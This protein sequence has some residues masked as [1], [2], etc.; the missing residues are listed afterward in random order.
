MDVVPQLPDTAVLCARC[1]Q[2]NTG[3]PNGFPQVEAAEHSG[4]QP[5]KLCHQPHSP[6]LMPQEKKS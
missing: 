6:L 3:K 2:A 4:G 1:H 5:C